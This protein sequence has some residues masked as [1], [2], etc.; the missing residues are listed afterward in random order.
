[1]R[2]VCLAVAVAAAAMPLAGLV[3]LRA[4]AASAATEATGQVVPISWERF[5][6]GL[7]RDDQAER[8]RAILL[9]AN[10][11]ALRTWFPS[12]YGSQTS[13]YLD[14]GGVAEGH[15]RPPGS[16]AL[17]LATSVAT[18]AYDQDATGH[19]E[20]QARH[21]AVRLL[22]SI[23]YHHKANTS[24]GWG[25]DW[26]SALWAFNA[27]FA[28]WLLWDDLDAA[29]RAL[30][31]RMV[32]AEADRFLY[33]KVP[34]YQDPEGRVITPGDSK[35][36]ENAWNAA[37][38]NLAM[39][40]IPEHP[41]RAVWQDKAIELMVSAYS[42]PSDLRNDTLVNGRTVAKWLNGSNIFEDGTLVNHGRIHPD[43]FTSIANI[44]GAPLAYGLAGLP[45]PRAAFFNAD[46][47]YDALV[48]HQFASPPYAA[49]GGT[50][51]LREQAG[52]ATADIYY[53]QGNDWGSSRQMHFLLL[54]TLA[55]TYD[56]DGL[57]SV[58]AADWAVAHATRALQMQSRFDDGRTYGAPSE[59]TYAGREEWVALLAGRTYLTHWL[60][61]NAD[62]AVTDRA[63]PVTPRD[64]PGASMTLNAARSYPKGLATPLTL[65]LQ[66]RS[67]E[68]L[69]NLSVELWLPD[70]WSAVRTDAVGSTVP[71][72]ATVTLAWQVTPGP[73]AAEGTAEL[74]ATARYRHY[75]LDRRLDASAVVAVPPGVNVALGRPTTVS[76]ALRATSRGD[77]AVDG[78]FTDASRWISAEGDP[79]PVITIDL[80]RS[81]DIGS[82]YVYSGY[83]AT[84][85]DPTSTL[86]DF[87]VEV[88]TDDGWRQVADI[89]GNVEHRVVFNGLDVTGD[90]VRLSISDPSGSTVDVA[91][92]FEVEVYEVVG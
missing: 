58:P 30:V 66:R 39:S 48:D 23:A 1:M 55:D 19:P 77:K 82:V 51:Y 5:D 37:F 52:L 64:Y 34:Y 40:M 74:S 69:K 57:V 63:Y 87:A 54:D 65:T 53:P 35:A 42:R 24:N 71:P 28:G 9:N 33:Y 14:L 38:L 13:R 32:V 25:E 18:G 76:S 2:T 61:H 50:I 41:N 45:T 17:A 22:T 21:V 89:A 84:N 44:V 62:L 60:D 12:K 72:G 91:R 26:Q 88:H 10:Q 75:G 27:A 80:G 67:E 47:V 6:A 79:A 46:I 31:E 78:L 43:Y 86:K 70:G 73:G 49:P 29:D 92:V 81:V 15:I 85:H 11:Y 8:A 3:P 90:Q 59:D 36:E 16:E 83:N 68:P 20:Q 56:L 7:P 4:P